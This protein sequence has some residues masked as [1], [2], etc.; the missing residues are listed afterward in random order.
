M[1]DSSYPSLQ[2]FLNVLNPVRGFGTSFKDRVWSGRRRGGSSPF[3]IV[4]WKKSG[5]VMGMWPFHLH[6]M[7]GIRP[8]TPVFRFLQSFRWRASWLRLFLV[9]SV[10]TSRNKNGSY[11]TAL[12][13]GISHFL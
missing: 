11:G 4:G 5:P 3:R 7:L 8:L 6:N 13:Q 9:Y 10:G 2:R 12:K 1:K